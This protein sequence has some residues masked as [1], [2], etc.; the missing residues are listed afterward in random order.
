MGL[1][2][3]HAGRRLLLA[4]VMLAQDHPVMPEVLELQCRHRRAYLAYVCRLFDDA[5]GE[6]NNRVR[7]I[8]RNQPV[9][10]TL[11]ASTMKSPKGGALT[12]VS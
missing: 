1:I 3:E 4:D 10:T 5:E 11:I 2:R 12:A 8:D 7:R 9:V 6:R